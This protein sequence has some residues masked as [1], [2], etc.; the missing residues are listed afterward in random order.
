MTQATDAPPAPARYDVSADVVSA[1]LHDGAVV[2]H[3]GTKRYYSLNETGALVW[4]MLE[5]GAGR[6]EI[7]AAL[8]HAFEVDAEAA[9]AAVDRL[10]AEL[11]AERLLTPA[12]AP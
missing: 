1:A 4:Q 6:A 2:L 12:P 10:V 3:M 11:A 5:G 8:R 9:G 7:V